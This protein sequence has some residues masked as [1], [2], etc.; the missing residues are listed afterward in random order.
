MTMSPLCFGSITVITLLLLVPFVAAGPNDAPVVLGLGLASAAGT[1]AVAAAAV[2]G[3]I[4][5]STVPLREVPKQVVQVQDSRERAQVLEHRPANTKSSYGDVVNLSSGPALEWKTWCAAGPGVLIYGHVTPFDKVPYDVIV[6]PDKKNQYLSTHV[7]VRPELNSALKPIAGTRA[8]TS[9]L[10]KHSKMLSDLY[11][12]QV[13]DQPDE[14]RD[15]PAPSTKGNA[16]LLASLGRAV[17]ATRRSSRIPVL[18]I[19]SSSPII[20]AINANRS[21]PSVF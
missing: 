5:T 9:V 8:G 21:G 18:R 4:G 14:M 6:T 17:A 20:R 13:C 16:P 15:I 2:A 19:A 1:I 12:Q 11:K 10:K 7:S 3:A